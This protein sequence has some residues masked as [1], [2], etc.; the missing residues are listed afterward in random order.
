V[1]TKPDYQLPLTTVLIDKRFAFVAMP[2]E[3]LSSFKS[4]G[5]NTVRCG[6]VSF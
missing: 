1:K 3:P 2:G 5:A 6:I 4:N